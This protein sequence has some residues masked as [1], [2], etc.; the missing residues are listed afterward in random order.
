MSSS[1]NGITTSGANSMRITGMASGID[2]EA[3]VKKLMTAQQ[4]KLDKA[5]QAKQALLWKQLAYADIITDIKGLQSSFFDVAS[6]DTNLLSGSNYAAFAVTGNNA[7]V[8]T[9]T[10]G[11]GS[12]I[13]SYTLKVIKTA[14]GA[15]YSNNVTS[16][17][18]SSIALTSKL[19]QIGTESMS[20]VLSL[21]LNLNGGQT[22]NVSLDNT[23][24]TKTVKDLLNAINTQGKGLVT[25]SYSEL[26]QSFSLK[27]TATGDAVTMGV[28]SSSSVALQKLIAPGSS[29]NTV[30]TRG[31]YKSDGTGLV[32]TSM[33]TEVGTVG[34]A[35]KV[36][37][38]L[39][40]NIGEASPVTI[41][42]DNTDGSKS[43]QDI[44][45]AINA[46]GSGKVTASFD[47]VN[48]NLV[49]T[50]VANPTKS[51]TVDSSTTTVLKNVL[52][53][54]QSSS[55]Q[56]NNADVFITEP[57]QAAVEVKNQASNN[58]TIDGVSYS[59]SGTTENTGDIKLNVT[60]DSQKV[61]DKFKSFIDKYNTIVTKIQKKLLDKPDPAYKPLTDAQKDSMSD[62]QIKTWETK[63]QVGILRNDENLQKLLTD[64]KSAFTSPV[65]GVNLAISKYGSNSIGLDTSNDVYNP[66][67]ITI[68][69]PLKLKA[70]I[71]QNPEQIIKMFS[72][73]SKSTDKTTQYNENGIFSRIK[74]LLK[75]NVGET[76]TISVSATL[77]K[78]ANK[79]LNF[80]AYGSGGL[81][82]IPDQMY[83]KDV[84]IKKLKTDF[85]TMETAYYN[86]FSR[87]E[88]A[89][90]QLNNQQSSLTSMLG[91]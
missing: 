83:A 17:D 80:S 24:G 4:L 86:K 47:D 53:P 50:N 84:L 68:V 81:Q 7:A 63:A 87:L 49:L 75:S 62:D 51:I 27:S 8:G 19:S 59:I 29:A 89:M 22:V 2:V 37:M 15:S 45:N 60:Q 66:C 79:Q 9:V 82:T 90:T 58:F 88:T 30:N 43:F 23:S 38:N 35:F 65:D 16:N 26:T 42:L 20:D 3:T 74:D 5:N 11:V 40:L 71:S 70:A 1:S 41:N 61:F 91:K 13:G 36:N 85:T 69:D 33:L 76:G 31:F 64:L 46:Q 55:K 18:G 10:A 34:D 21:N 52:G 48:H 14:A 56:G 44:V 32:S 77:T 78:Y 6:S 73:V 25:A 28:D 57:G 39:N 67:N 72:N 54:L 12:Q